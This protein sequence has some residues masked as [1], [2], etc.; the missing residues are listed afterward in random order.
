[1][2]FS[3][4]RGFVLGE[5][6]GC[7]GEGVDWETGEGY[8]LLLFLIIIIIIII[9]IL[10]PPISNP[11]HPPTLPIPKNINLTLWIPLLLHIQFPFRG[12]FLL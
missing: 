10:L 3:K 7:V 11:S 9:I 2:A 1:M 5:S 8:L 12:K 4:A 6:G